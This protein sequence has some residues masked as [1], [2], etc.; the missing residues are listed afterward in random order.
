[1]A[2]VSGTAFVFTRT[3]QACGERISVTIQGDTIALGAYA[4]DDK[5]RDTRARV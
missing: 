2:M 1:M 5:V 3:S 4:D